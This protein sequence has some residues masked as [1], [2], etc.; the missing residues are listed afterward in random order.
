MDKRTN[1]DSLRHNLLCWRCFAD[2]TGSRFDKEHLDINSPHPLP[3]PWLANTRTS[4]AIMETTRLAP[5]SGPP[6]PYQKVITKVYPYTLRPVMIFINFLGFI[7]ALIVGIKN[8]MDVGKRG[9]K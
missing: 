6:P 1:K 3:T 9:G 4:S 7:W 2:Y 5:P 8:L